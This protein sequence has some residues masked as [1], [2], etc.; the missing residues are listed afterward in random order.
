MLCALLVSR[1]LISG[2]KCPSAV[3]IRRSR[4][5]TLSA[6]CL[7]ERVACACCRWI[8]SSKKG[9]GGRQERPTVVLVVAC[10]CVRAMGGLERQRVRIGVLRW[11]GRCRCRWEV[12]MQNDVTCEAQA[13][14]LRS[15]SRRVTPT[16]TCGLRRWVSSESKTKKKKKTKNRAPPRDA[17]RGEGQPEIKFPKTIQKK[18]D[19]R[20]ISPRLFGFRRNKKRCSAPCS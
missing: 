4:R 19:L 6:A 12:C 7:P 3:S 1:G 14:H 16:A 2:V 18:I 20:P 10:T 8:E 17:R 11:W 5:D 15:V 9:V 13:K